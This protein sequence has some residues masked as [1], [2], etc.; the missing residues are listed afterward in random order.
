[1]MM[2]VSNRERIEVLQEVLE[3]MEEIARSLRS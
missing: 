3:R 2:A 1:M